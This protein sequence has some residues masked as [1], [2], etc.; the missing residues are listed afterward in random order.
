[1]LTLDEAVDF[2]GADHLAPVALGTDPALYVDGQTMF[3]AGW[4][5]SVYT[6]DQPLAVLQWVNVALVNQN[7]CRSNYLLV[8]MITATQVCAGYPAG[9]KGICTGDAGGPLLALDAGVY[10]LI[11]IASWSTGCAWKNYPS[12]Y[13]RI[14]AAA[15]WIQSQM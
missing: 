12:V 4:G 8:N 9:G 7:T 11:G 6:G 15:D 2:T 14:S 1:V 3:T 13:T 10:H 5:A